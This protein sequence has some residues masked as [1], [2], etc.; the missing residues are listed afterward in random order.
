[1]GSQSELALDELKWK[2][3]SERRKHFVASLMHKITHE[4]APK[5][6]TDIFQR[7]SL[8]KPKTEYLKKICGTAF[9]MKQETNIL[10]LHL[11]TRPTRITEH[12]VT[13]IDN[14]FT[15]DLEQ[16]EF[17]KNGLIFTDISDHLPIFHIASL[18]ILRG[19]I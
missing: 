19:F 15:N 11:I 1:V 14:I 12:T 10:L 17:S 4:L 13:L 3:L 7:T 9:Q 5:R 6:L 16:I 18:T 8:P 2:P